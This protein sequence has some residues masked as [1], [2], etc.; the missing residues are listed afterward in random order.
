MTQ[1]I[2]TRLR[3][4]LGRMDWMLAGAV[5]G[6]F[7]R[8][9]LRANGVRLRGRVTLNGIPYVVNRGDFEVGHDVCITSSRVNPVAGNIRTSFVVAPGASLMIGERAG[10]SH[11]EVYCASSIAIGAR[12]LI[13]GGVRIYDSDFHPV[14]WRDRRDSHKRGKT[15]P[16][17]I[18]ADCFIGAF[19][20]ILKGVTIGEG[21]VLG[22]GS[23][24][25]R[26]IPAGEIWAGNP[27][28]CIRRV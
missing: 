14:D 13:G 21:S 6:F 20:T 27:A 8:E 7:G 3:A 26:P 1:R 16:V 9:Y 24:A 25:S 17:V 11:C 4:A 19:A 18:G 2:S 12:T 22:A 15:R 28:V 10:L 23:V 5:V